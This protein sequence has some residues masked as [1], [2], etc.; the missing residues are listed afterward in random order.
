GALAT[1][2]YRM[3]GSDAGVV[4]PLTIRI[5]DQVFFPIS[6]VLDLVLSRF[7]GKNLLIVG[8]RR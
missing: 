3:V 4:D 1:L 6:R 7:V 8:H 5:Y 2:T